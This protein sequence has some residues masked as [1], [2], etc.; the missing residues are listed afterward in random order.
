MNFNKIVFASFAALIITTAGFAQVKKK[1]VR[2]VKSKPVAA[3]ANQTK[4]AGLPIDPNVITGKLPNGLTYYIRNNGLPKNLATLMLVNKVGSVLESDAQRGATHFVEHMAFNGTRNFP[5]SDLTAYLNSRGPGNGPDQTATASFD[6]TVYQLTVPTDT[7]SIFD[8]GFKLLADWAGNITFDAADIEAERAK[9][10]NEINTTGNTVQERIQKQSMPFLLKNSRY[11]SRFPI[12]DAEAFKKLSAGE[13]KK[14][15]HDW[16]RP[17]LQAIVVVG[18][19]DVKR[20]EQLIKDNFSALKNPAP[21]KPRTMY[22]R[23]PNSGTS[24]NFITDK[25]FPY[26]E[27]QIIVTQPLTPVKTTADFMQNIRISLFNQMLGARISDVASQNKTL[28]LGAQASYGP[29]YGRQNAFATVVAA[30]TGSLQPALTA[31]VAEVERARKF[32]FTLT[33]LERAKQNA[34]L[35]V[36]NLYQNKD[37]TYSANYISQYIQNFLTGDPITGIDYE[38]NYYTDN[39]GKIT[40]DEVNTLAAKFMSVQ[41]RMINITAPESEKSKLPDENTLLTWINNA[42]KDVTAYVDETDEP[43]MDKAPAPGKVVK[44]EQDSVIYITKLTLS[45][46]VKVI[47]KPTTFTDNQILIN[48]YGFGGTSLAPAQD[49]ASATL[50]DKLISNSG[51]GNLTQQQVNKRLS[52]KQVNISPYISDITQGVTGSSTPADFEYAMQLLHLYF[53]SPRKDATVWQDLINQ[54]KASIAKKATDPLSAYQDTIALILNNHNPRALEITAD[55]LNSASI[56]KAYDFY[57]NRFADASNFTFT[58]IGSFKVEQIIP[59]IEA[60]LGSLPSTHKNETYKNLGLHPQAGQITKTVTVGN[61]DKASVQLTYS[62][63]YDYN[64]ANNVQMDALEEVLNLRLDSALTEKLG[65]F[66]PGAKISY[67]KI[68]E[69]RYEATIY[70]DATPSEAYKLTN[71]ALNEINS[72]KQ[73][74]ALDKEVKTFTLTD[75]RDTQRHYRENIFWAGYLSTSAQNQDD[76][77]KILEHIQGL[78]QVTP[79]SVKDAANK[80]LSGA[81]LIKLTLLPQKK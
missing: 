62:G 72:I 43:F 34:L 53:T 5:K 3:A 24:V 48:G 28:L 26:E 81:N 70:F 47:L 69:G 11:A 56:D 25:E 77:H 59:F 15:Y 45:N 14:F 75:A 52:S 37:N 38:Y 23:V 22:A 32:G 39:V 49:Y 4:A 35:S 2:S 13:I 18:D 17:D 12:P 31:V 51:V 80:Y 33:E 20:V 6:E 76:P 58:F 79:Q 78:E 63:V 44:T 27:A 8:K 55:N 36:S 1:P 65:A 71:L 30:R 21:E 64:E 40:L 74:G 29:F 7:A 42:G 66:S 60:Y 73:N 41:N 61:S 46:G 50:A 54:S 10:I 16:Y 19:F 68:P 57:K 67:T 9:I